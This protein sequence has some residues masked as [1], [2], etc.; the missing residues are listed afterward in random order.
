MGLQLVHY[1]AYLLHS[2]HVH[3]FITLTT[4]A[5]IYYTYYIGTYLLHLL[6]VLLIITL[7]TCALI[8]YTYYMRTV[9]K[10]ES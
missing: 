4:S 3:L 9:S 1:S 6:H 2:L 7:I 10:T 5:L 8:Y